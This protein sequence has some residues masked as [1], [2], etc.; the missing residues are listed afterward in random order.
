M[1]IFK[2]ED[3]DNKIKK[4]DIS[5][6]QYSAIWCSPCQSLKPIMAALSEK[7]KDK[8]NFYYADV[9]EGALNHGASMG[10]RGVPSTIVFHKGKE[11]DRLIGNPGEA[12]VKEFL[13]LHI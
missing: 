8:A 2:D 13:D 1:L 12:K 6:I 4:E 9:E 5:V 3:W 10:I 7:Y 11:V